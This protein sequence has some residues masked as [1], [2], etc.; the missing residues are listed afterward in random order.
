MKNKTLIGLAV[1]A[2]LGSPAAMATVVK[3]TV[4]NQQGQPVKGAEVRIE[5]SK[6]VT[7]T[8]EQGQY[9]FDNV[10]IEHI[11]LHVYSSEYVHGDNDLGNVS[12]DQVVD[13]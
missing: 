11:H 4:N 1:M 7:F 5:G 12:T 6:Q 9:Q 8:N 10:R 3:G 13:F 2:A